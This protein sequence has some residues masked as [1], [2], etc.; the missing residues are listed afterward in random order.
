MLAEGLI[1]LHFM[2]PYTL[3]RN[4]SQTQQGLIVPE[5]IY[6]PRFQCR[7]YNMLVLLGESKRNKKEDAISLWESNY[8]N[9]WAVISLPLPLLTPVLYAIGD[10]KGSGEARKGLYCLY[11]VDVFFSSSSILPSPVLRSK[12]PDFPLAK[13]LI[14]LRM[15]ALLVR[16]VALPRNARMPGGC[17]LTVKSIKVHFNWN[18]ILGE[19]EQKGQG[20]WKKG[21][22]KHSGNVRII[23]QAS[24]CYQL[25]AYHWWHFLHA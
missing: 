23:T 9:T 17:V 21:I 19:E 18:I 24:V 4:N 16:L 15:S 20:G 14:P 3:F 7:E 6:T 1:H 5:K 8:P 2:F 13:F 12:A 22:L 11:C 25:F 10:N